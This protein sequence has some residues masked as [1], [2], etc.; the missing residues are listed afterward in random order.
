M[1]DPRS[2][3]FDEVV[4]RSSMPRA[5]SGESGDSDGGVF[6]VGVDDASSGAIPKA[7]LESLLGGA[8]L[9]ATP[10][11]P[12]S[13]DL[14]ASALSEEEQARGAAV[15]R[16][17]VEAMEARSAA[18]AARERREAFSTTS[19]GSSGSLDAEVLPPKWRASPVTS[20]RDSPTHDPIPPAFATND[21]FAEN[22]DFADFSQFTSNWPGD[23]HGSDAT[24]GGIGGTEPLDRVQAEVQP[25]VVVAPPTSVPTARVAPIPPPA[26]DPGFPGRSA[27]SLALDGGPMSANTALELARAQMIRECEGLLPSPHTPREGLT[28]HQRT[29][30]PPAG[31]FCRPRFCSPACV[32]KSCAG[33]IKGCG[34]VSGVDLADF[35][36]ITKALKKM[37]IRNHP[38]RHSVARVGEQSAARATALTQQVSFLQSMLEDFE[39]APV[40][41]RVVTDPSPSG[42]TSEMH[43]VLPRVHLGS[44]L[45]QLW[46]ALVEECPGLGWSK[47]ECGIQ[48]EHVTSAPLAFDG[49]TLR[50]LKFTN[51]SEFRVWRFARIDEVKKRGTPFGSPR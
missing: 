3:F 6:G 35:P 27:D 12:A 44:T 34:G 31:E 47:E 45:E 32:A 4:S 15:E 14:R 19:K 16:S 36:A 25:P 5:D 1:S 33:F 38:D 8:T 18:R 39:Y 50:K 28:A 11:S 29:L 30:G 2:T 7:S 37:A 20:E 41:I 46:N 48:L 49:T 23:A 17:R 10:P 42:Q 26:N 21:F 51:N 40:R 22:D 43:V 13:V 24:G 9:D